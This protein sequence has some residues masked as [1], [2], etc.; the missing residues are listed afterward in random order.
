MATS[1][2]LF[3]DRSNSTIED[4]AADLIR[5][6]LLLA[7]FHRLAEDTDARANAAGYRCEEELWGDIS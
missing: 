5:R 7:E 3:A 1:L 6:H 2:R 4:A